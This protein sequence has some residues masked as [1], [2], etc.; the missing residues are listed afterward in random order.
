VSHILHLH[1]RAVQRLQAA[2]DAKQS[3]LDTAIAEEKFDDC[4]AM[5]SE[6]DALTERLETVQDKSAELT[7][8]ANLLAAACD[9][10]PAEAAALAEEV[11]ALDAE[12]AQYLEAS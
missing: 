5:Q 1:L 2:K 12:C 8:K 11:A 6:I 4:D 9:E 3:D 7:D 10:D